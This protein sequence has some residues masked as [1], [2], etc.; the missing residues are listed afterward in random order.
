M[1]FLLLMIVTLD[2]PAG[3]GKSS[4]ARL[5]ARRIG[6]A[7]L[8]TGAMYRGVTWCCKQR[9]IALE[10]EEA[11][12]GVADELRFDFVEEKVFINGDNVTLLIRTNQIT[13][14]IR[15]VADNVRVRRR[16]VEKQREWAGTRN[17][18]TEGRDQGT[19]AFPHAE[20][21][22]YLTASPEERARRR[23]AQ[24]QSQGIKADFENI[25]MS[26]MQRDDEDINRVEGGLK[27]APDAI[28]VYTDG[29]NEE[30]VLDK[31]VVLVREKRGTTNMESVSVVS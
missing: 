10:D 5:L 30:Q 11:V 19:V 18:V 24:L 13:E 28:Y 6:F 23:V 2:G 25:L 4:I 22:I 14:S 15:P 26:Q 3:A 1:E 17:V 16:L 12:L 20:C 31:L 7:F 29:L 8:D 21:K 27:A 9:G